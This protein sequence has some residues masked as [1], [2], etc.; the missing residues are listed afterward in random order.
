MSIVT[1]FLQNGLESSVN[2]GHGII[3]EVGSGVAAAGVAMKA[4]SRVQQGQMGVRTSLGR[5]VRP[6][7]RKQGELYGI[8]GPGY[9]L[10]WPFTHSIRTIDTRDRTNDLHQIQVE[11]RDGQQMLVE[12]SIIWAVRA[13]DD[14]PYR[15]LFHPEDG[16][17]TET[18]VRLCTSGLRVVVE[19]MDR[20]QMKQQREIS[21]NVKDECEDDLLHYGVE[22]KKVNLH[23]ATATWAEK[24]SQ[25]QRSPEAAFLGALAMNT[26]SD[27]FVLPSMRYAPE[28]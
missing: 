11:S 22:L 25:M 20:V 19:G 24:L 13:D 12:S 10:V 9:H 26:E 15:A 5:A 23:T 4:F 16:A 21:G 2:A 17:L 1:S 3:A 18:V 28:G 27:G 8:V 7:G 14:N 6:K